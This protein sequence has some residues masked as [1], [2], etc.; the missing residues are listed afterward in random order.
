[1][2]PPVIFR[3]TVR[4]GPVI[5]SDRT[6][7]SWGG[8]RKLFPCAKCVCSTLGLS[9]SR[10]YPY[11]CKIAD[12]ARD[13]GP[14][15]FSGGSVD[16]MGPLVQSNDELEG[17]KLAFVQLNAITAFAIA[18]SHIE[19]DCG[20]I[21]RNAS[22]VLDSSHLG[23]CLAGTWGILAMGTF[24]PFHIFARESQ[25]HRVLSGEFSR[26]GLEPITDYHTANRPIVR[27]FGVGM[28]AKTTANGAEPTLSIL[29]H[30]PV[31][32]SGGMKSRE[33]ATSY[34]RRYTDQ[35]NLFSEG[36]FD[37]RTSSLGAKIGRRRIYLGC[38]AAYYPSITV[39]VSNFGYSRN[40]RFG[41]WWRNPVIGRPGGQ[42]RSRSSSIAQDHRMGGHGNSE[43]GASPS[44]TGGY[45][46]NPQL[47]NLAVERY[48]TN[49][50]HM[51]FL[52]LGNLV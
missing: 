20:D 15:Q 26:C 30:A 9:H 36:G 27:N 8:I 7:C 48:F 42:P 45:S 12:L 13:L 3:Y 22:L 52:R 2:L 18:S 51:P 47:R 4:I 38:A 23:D 19:I 34:L 24:R 16:F 43:M 11:H 39:E 49:R 1:M 40:W 35:F 14:P 21:F 37:G 6:R 41:E 25:S 5:L 46:D 10:V 33:M 31:P 28:I 29:S 44:F 17:S 50:I 32:I